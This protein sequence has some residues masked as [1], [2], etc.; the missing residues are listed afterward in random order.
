[1]EGMEEQFEIGK[2]TGRTLRSV[3]ERDISYIGWILNNREIISAE[4][5]PGLSRMKHLIKEKLRS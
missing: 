4:D 2:Y 1:M 5:G 3:I